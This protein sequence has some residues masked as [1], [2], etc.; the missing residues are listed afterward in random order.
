MELLNYIFKCGKLILFI[1][2]VDLCEL[3]CT[4]PLSIVASSLNPSN[5]GFDSWF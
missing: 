4:M 1:Y 2:L 5:P 3:D